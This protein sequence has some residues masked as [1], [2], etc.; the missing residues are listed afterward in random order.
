MQTKQALLALL[1][2]QKSEAEALA[3][4][5]NADAQQYKQQVDALELALL[6]QAEHYTQ[7][8]KQLTAEL[9]N[10]QGQ[11]A[12]NKRRNALL[13]K[14]QLANKQIDLTED[15]TRALIDEQLRQVGWQVD[16]QTMRFELGTRPE[17]KT[18]KAIAEWEVAG[19]KRADYVLFDGLT[20]IAVIEAKRKHKN[21]Y[22]AI[23][24]AKVYPPRSSL[25]RMK[26]TLLNDW[27]GFKIPFAF[28]SNGRAYLPQL[29][30]ESGIWFLDLR[31]TY[32]PRRALEH[33]YSPQDLRDYLKHNTSRQPTNYRQCHFNL[34][35][36]YA[37]I[38]F[39]RFKPLNSAL[40][41]P[42]AIS[43]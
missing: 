35:S 19:K 18:F 3:Q 37:L 40:A 27:Q 25:K 12:Q 28:A 24:P 43:Y 13:K 14:I 39:K 42:S 32:Q 16:N 21:V 7:Q 34:I 5:M 22:S 11:A 9:A 36:I 26:P 31:D 2:Q 15:M 4:L 17:P 20:P 1:E 30:Q 33:W 23:D 38:K 10:Q 41:K 8:F 6:Q 29:A